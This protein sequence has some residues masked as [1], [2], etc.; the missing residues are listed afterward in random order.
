[1]SNVVSITRSDDPHYC[2]LPISEIIVQGRHRADLGDIKALAES[3][4][5]IG[6]IHAP[7][8]TPDHH[9]LAGE[10]R[11]AALRMLGRTVVPVVVIH[12]LTDATDRLRAERDENTCRKDFTASEL[13]SIGRRLEELE[14][15]KAQARQRES[16]GDRKSAEYRSGSVEPDRS[17]SAPTNRVVGEALGVS[18]STYKRAK[19]VV[20]ATEDDD[21]EVATVARDQLAKLDAGEVSYTAADQAVRDVRNRKKEA[22][23]FTDPGVDAEAPEPEVIPGLP[24]KVKGPRPNHLKMLTRIVVGL[25]GT[26]MALDGI[27]EVN[28][29]VN[30]EEARRLMSDLS[31][32]IRSLNRINKLLKERIR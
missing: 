4:E 6:L 30:A 31:Q 17:G 8:V 32:S 10:R 26:V 1:M 14:R 11:L 9:L 15:P 23:D 22:I 24:T 27:E 7:A 18:P 3:I 12:K 25:S 28:D 29:T 16:G 20:S 19:T 2:E 21:L 13:V 5:S